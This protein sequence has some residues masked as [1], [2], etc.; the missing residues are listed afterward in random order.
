MSAIIVY[1]RNAIKMVYV[2]SDARVILSVS[3]VIVS[4]I[5][6][7]YRNNLFTFIGVITIP[8]WIADKTEKNPTY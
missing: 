1:K 5:L 2:I 6:I 4:L 8:L 3:N 7:I